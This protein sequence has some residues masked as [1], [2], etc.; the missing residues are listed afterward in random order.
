[1]TEKKTTDVVLRPKRQITLPRMVCKHLGIEPG[2]VLE[3][4]LED[5]RLVARPRKRVALE[6]LREIQR[7]FERSGISEEDLQKAGRQA[8]Q[9]MARERYRSDA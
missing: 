8:R 7:A 9:E 2:D 4:L 5:D 6:A 1:M 3:L